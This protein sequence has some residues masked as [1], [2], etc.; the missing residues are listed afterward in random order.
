MVTGANDDEECIEWVIEKHIDYL[1]TSTPLHINRYY[2]ANKYHEP[3]TS[4]KKLLKAYEIARNLGIE[5]VYIG[6]I[7]DEEY[8]DTYC[9]KC[10]K[11]LIERRRYRVTYWGLDK[12]NKCPRCGY[13]INIFGEYM[14]MKETPLFM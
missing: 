9:P 5:Y 3:A 14:P 12:D 11:K 7:I 4:M 8:Q 6:N 1:G 10:G 13:K 2:P